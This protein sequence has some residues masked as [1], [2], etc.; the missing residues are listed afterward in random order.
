MVTTVR[1]HRIIVSPSS[2]ARGVAWNVIVAGMRDSI[3]TGAAARDR[4][5]ECALRRAED[6]RT[7]G[8]ARVVVEPCPA[9]VPAAGVMNARLAS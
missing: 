5:I 8:A 4:A 2:S 7:D 6:L 3:F 1:S 9:V